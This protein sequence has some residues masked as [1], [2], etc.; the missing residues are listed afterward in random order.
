MRDIR[1]EES[2]EPP[3]REHIDSLPPLGGESL[4]MDFSGLSLAFRG[5]DG[6]LA[7]AAQKRFQAYLCDEEAPTSSS[8]SSPPSRRLAPHASRSASSSFASRLEIAAHADSISY[9]VEPDRGT[10]SEG[11]Y[12]LRILHE[13]G[14]I[15][16]V[17]YGMA[18]WLDPGARRGAVSFTKDEWD[19]RERALENLCRVAI[20]W[21]AVERGGF[22]IHG[23]SIVRNG[24]AYIF[25]GRS[26]SGKSTLA[27]LSTE[28][29]VISDDLSLV[30]PS[31]KGMLVAGTPFRGTW[32]GGAPVKGT[33]PLAAMFLL[34]QDTRTW[35]EEPSKIQAAAEYV[36]N[37]PFV[38]DALHA[39]PDLMERLERAAA[40]I[41]VKILHFRP[42][43]TFWFAVD[44]ALPFD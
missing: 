2:V 27:S 5:L 31:A 19:P 15:R 36:A 25:F 26:A 11:Y 33:F 32:G 8:P 29:Q 24:R 14:L 4:T 28:G 23:A 1:R 39:Y 43:P 7:R 44:K 13:K 37:L 34:A 6:A 35:V 41:P 30:F 38:N 16:L 20:A 12:R 42:D 17:T 9:Y 3:S 22:L 10:K 21:M 18:A 40:G